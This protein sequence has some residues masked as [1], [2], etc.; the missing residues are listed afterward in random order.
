MLHNHHHHHHNHSHD[1]NYYYDQLVC[2]KSL[3]S[4]EKKVTR[5]LSVCKL[6]YRWHKYIYVYDIFLVKSANLLPQG[7]RLKLSE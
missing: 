5:A 4:S 3:K 1:C 2:V 6:V 7:T